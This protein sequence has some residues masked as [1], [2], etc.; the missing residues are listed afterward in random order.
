MSGMNMSNQ[1]K[2][3]KMSAVNVF[4]INYDH[5][6]KVAAIKAFRAL[7]NN[8]LKVS[9][10]AIERCWAGYD[11]DNI[12]TILSDKDRENH[13]SN[14]FY[15]SVDVRA[16]LNILRDNGIKIDLLHTDIVHGIYV[17]LGQ[18]LDQNDFYSVGVLTNALDHACEP[19]DT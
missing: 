2:K 18:A 5:Y 11:Y 4:D 1:N 13:A 8:G 19:Y 6:N 3:F 16:Q 15:T 10:E 14:S 12:W 7:T 9:K 17:L